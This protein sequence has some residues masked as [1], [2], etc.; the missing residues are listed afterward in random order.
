MVSVHSLL[1]IDDDNHFL[2]GYPVPADDVRIPYFLEYNYA[3]DSISLRTAYTTYYYIQLPAMGDLLIC[4]C[5]IVSIANDI[6][7]E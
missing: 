2:V 3:E 5:V 4:C 1:A 7:L 6:F